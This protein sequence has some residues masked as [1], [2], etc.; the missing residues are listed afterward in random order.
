[1]DNELFSKILNDLDANEM[2][3]PKKTP[4]GG[5]ILGNIQNRPISGKP[6]DHWNNVLKSETNDDS[7]LI[8]LTKRVTELEKYL[9]VQRLELKEKTNIINNLN[10]ELET[11]K[12][13]I[14]K[15]AL[16]KIDELESSIKTKD[17]KIKELE[18]FLKQYG[19]ISK[20]NEDS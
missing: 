17:K 10:N 9:N 2:L 5:P 13:T 18:N 16:N 3:K 6:L 1:M 4:F 15:G 20:V 7:L 14:D 11:L 8:P 19:L 12:K